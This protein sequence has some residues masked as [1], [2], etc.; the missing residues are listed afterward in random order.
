MLA[1]A[2][3]EQ[4]AQQS[5]V[6]GPG[7]QQHVPRHRPACE[8]QGE[9]DDDDVVD[10]SKPG[11]DHAGESVTSGGDQAAWGQSKNDKDGSNKPN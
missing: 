8:A 1:S 6:L 5:G 11:D 3:A 9:G 2:V 7:L 4:P 10:D